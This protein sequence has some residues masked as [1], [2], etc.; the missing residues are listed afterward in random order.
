MLLSG[1]GR[2]IITDLN[3]NSRDANG[4]LLGEFN[5]RV[6]LGLMQRTDIAAITSGPL[7]GAFA[8]VDVNSGE[9][10]I[11]RLDN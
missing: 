1:A 4:F 3:G 8:I 10:V 6:K 7:A 2:V 5:H 9:I 11:F